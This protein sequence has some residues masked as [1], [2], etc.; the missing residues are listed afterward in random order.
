MP[1]M[2]GYLVPL[3]PRMLQVQQV[4]QLNSIVDDFIK[5]AGGMHE[6][7]SL[8]EAQRAEVRRLSTDM[9]VAEDALVMA[10]NANR[11][12][13]DALEK[14]AGC[15]DDA[16]AILEK[17]MTSYEAAEFCRFNQKSSRTWVKNMRM[18]ADYIKIATGVAR[19]FK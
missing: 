17:C 8:I 5:I 15:M 19:G 6:I 2:L 13:R 16:A 12:H 14:I 3:H 9:M 10:E 1:E 4:Q 7:S 11:G 18:V